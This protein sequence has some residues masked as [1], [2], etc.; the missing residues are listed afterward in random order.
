MIRKINWFQ[1][2]IPAAYMEE[3]ELMLGPL[4]GNIAATRWHYR[5]G[6]L[7]AGKI[8]ALLLGRQVCGMAGYFNDGNCFVHCA[9]PRHFRHFDGLLNGMDFHTLWMLN[10]GLSDA[11]RMKEAL[12]LEGR[13][14]EHFMMVQEAP[15]PVEKGGMEIVNI[16]GETANYEYIE[17]ACGLIHA[18]FD[19]NPQ[20]DLWVER[21]S[22]RTAAERYY[23]GK[24]DGAFVAQAHIQGWTP[25]YG[26][27]GGVTTA[28]EHRGKGYA[29]AVTG[30]LCAYVHE[31][32]RRPTLTV[33]THN[34]PALALYG[35]LGF[36]VAGEVTV[37]ETS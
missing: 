14:I 25:H 17:A 27:I 35:S 29:R 34:R 13:V 2:D 26:H 31:S 8:Y 22:E 4:Y 21:L 20:R 18:G 7:R 24:V 33:K 10:G 37:L 28:P 11:L 15:C 16:Q 19:Y 5:L 9:E 6:S 36:A 3:N 32:Q 23:L 12:G 30:Q 1:K